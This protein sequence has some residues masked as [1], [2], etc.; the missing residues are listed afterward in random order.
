MKRIPEISQAFKG[1]LQTIGRSEL[2]LG[3]LLVAVG[4]FSFALGRLSTLE[5]RAG[6]VRICLTS[7]SALAG[8][9]SVGLGLEKVGKVSADS[10]EGT[11]TFMASKSGTKYYPKGC[12]AGDRI[13]EENR[14]WFE[15]R[16]A[17]EAAGYAPALNCK[18]L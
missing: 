16:E 18:G 11:G 3:M 2:Y 7:E 8:Q 17:A 4:L 6:E 9:A 1:Q 10:H 15:S 5:A 12:R 13:K 14:I